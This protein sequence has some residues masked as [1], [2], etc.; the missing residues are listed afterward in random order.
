MDRRYRVRMQRYW[1]QQ[2]QKA[3][4][5]IDH[6]AVES[7]FDLWHTHIDWHSCGNKCD[8]TRSDAALLTCVVLQYALGKFKARKDPIQIWAIICQDTSENAV[9]IHSQNPNGSGFPYDFGETTWGIEIP[10]ELR[11]L[12]TFDQYEMGE[13]NFSGK[14]YIVRK[15]T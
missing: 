6:L 7:W 9:Y 15:R 4:S 5:A 3:F 11:S 10:K 12:D 8:E 1:N 14:I 2:R 13:M